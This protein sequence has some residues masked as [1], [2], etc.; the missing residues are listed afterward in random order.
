MSVRFGREAG[1][2]VVELLISALI[3]VIVLAIAGAFL[4]QQ[5]RMQRATQN[6]SELQDRVRV[7]MQL[8]TQDLALAGNSAVIATDGGKL[9]ITWPGCFDG[10]AGCVEVDD[11][12]SRLKLRYLSSQFATGNECR[13]VTYRLA[14]G[15]QFQ[16]SDVACGGNDDFVELASDIRQFQVTIHCSN[17]LDLN[18]FPSP[19]CPPLSSYGRSAT[20]DLVGQSRAPGDGMAGPACDAGFLCFALTQETLMPNMKDQ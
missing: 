9:D 5:T 19:Q 3:V 17:A 7:G 18:T 4:A 15:G 11:A 6:R 8:V 10:A 1:F 20:V 14:A 2:T 16:R 12:G 13:D